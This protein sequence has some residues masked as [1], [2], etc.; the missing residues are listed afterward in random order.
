VSS[1]PP[2]ILFGFERT[3][4]G[5]TRRDVS[6]ALRHQESQANV[7]PPPSRIRN[8]PWSFT[9]D[10]TFQSRH[11]QSA[12]A[13]YQV[14]IADYA[15]NGKVIDCLNICKEIKDQGI[16][17]NIFIYNDLL[18]AASKDGLHMIC[19]GI[20]DDMIATGVQP[21]RQSYHHLIYVQ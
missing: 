18:K 3:L 5:Q 1:P 14:T 12:L 10:F 19:E 2:P 7:T 9:P 6:T 15:E 17:P 21:D 16:R 11:R 20:I 13:K 8:A 4:L